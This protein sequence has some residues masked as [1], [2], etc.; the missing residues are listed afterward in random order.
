MGNKYYF[1]SDKIIDVLLILG[2]VILGLN[3]TD[4][5]G[6]LVLILFLRNI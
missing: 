3:H 1:D 6:W 4:G 5:W 2:V